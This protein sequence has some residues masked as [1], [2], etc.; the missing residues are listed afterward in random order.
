VPAGIRSYQGA[1]DQGGPVGAEPDDQLGDLLG[2]DEPADGFARS[3]RCQTSGG[4]T[5]C[6]RSV[7][8][9][10]PPATRGLFI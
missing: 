7:M 4:V 9:G 5:A 10:R 6:A 8:P 2:L 3:M 1:V